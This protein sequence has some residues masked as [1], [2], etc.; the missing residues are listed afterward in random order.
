MVHHFL[1]NAD[2]E[3]QFRGFGDAAEG[4]D[5]STNATVLT[6]RD[7]VGREAATGDDTLSLCDE[8]GFADGRDV[9]VEGITDFYRHP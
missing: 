8:V 4:I 5:D 2:G 7:A 9:T 6:H 3:G 1:A